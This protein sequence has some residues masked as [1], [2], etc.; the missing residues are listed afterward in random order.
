MRQI[1]PVYTLS[2]I[3]EDHCVM[4]SWPEQA[5]APSQLLK[6]ERTPRY[7]ISEKSNVLLLG[8]EGCCLVGLPR[9][10]V[11]VEKSELLAKLMS[12]GSVY[13]RYAIVCKSRGAS[14]V[15]SWE[16]DM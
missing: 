2:W 8:L 5:H 14:D 3:V 9:V 13:V 7:A 12:D 15:L 16:E 6:P 1:L 4:L 10:G 11:S